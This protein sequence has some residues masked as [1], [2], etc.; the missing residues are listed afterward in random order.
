MT[1][2]RM[3][4]LRLI[5]NRL[6]ARPLRR[7]RR[8]REESSEEMARTDRRRKGWVGEEESSNRHTVVPHPG[9]IE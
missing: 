6:L 8:R 2:E 3:F 9:R 7:G 4:T 1:V 5:C